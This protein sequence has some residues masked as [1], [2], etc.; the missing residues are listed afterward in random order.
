VSTDIDLSPFGLGTSRLA[1]FGSAVTQKE[2]TQLILHALDHGVTTIDTADSYGSGDS[3][4][5]IARALGH[6]R[7]ECFLMTKAG[8][9]HADLPAIVSPVNQIATKIWRKFLPRQTFNRNYLL[10]A[11]EKSLKRL[12]TDHVDAFFL[13][14]PLIT[15]DG[16]CWETL[17]QIRRQGL[18]RLTGIATNLAGVAKQ[19]IASGQVQIVQTPVSPTV[20]DR[21]L[22][23]LCLENGIPVVANE[24]LKSRARLD[25]LGTTWNNVS[26]QFAGGALSNPRLLI[27]YA[28]S[29]PGVR[30]VLLGTK[31]TQHLSENIQPFPSLVSMQQ[32][33][34]EMERILA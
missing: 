18:S 24:V 1:S 2:A 29:Q 21:S 13:H 4:R 23:T 33:S 16:E 26:A 27:A 34:A 6:R 32:V 22:L 11:I 28:A 20:I 7:K 25:N 3:E 30:T 19:G 8:F 5:M 9:C 15:L 14:E 17:H 12:R 31:S 10:R